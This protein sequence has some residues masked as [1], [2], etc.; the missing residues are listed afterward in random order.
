MGDTILPCG[1]CRVCCQAKHLV[2]DL[3]DGDPVDSYKLDRR[4][5][6]Y[7]AKSSS[8]ACVY[9]KEHGCAIYDKRPKACR[10]F[11]CRDLVNRLDP[12]WYSEAVLKS[13]YRPLQRAAGELTRKH[14]I[15][16]AK[17][18]NSLLRG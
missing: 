4:N 11:D 13:T 2:V 3:K 17:R 8:G 15:S 12:F 5:E 7:L 16:I 14:K 9:L 1:Y 10:E 18:F 6:R